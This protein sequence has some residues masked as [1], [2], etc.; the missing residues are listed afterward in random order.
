MK[1]TAFATSLPL[2]V[3]PSLCG[4]SHS[5]NRA[6]KTHVVPMNSAPRMAFSSIERVL[7]P[8]PVALP[9]EMEAVIACVYKQVFGNAYLMQSEREELAKTESQFARTENIREF[10][11]SL[12]KSNT[13]QSRFFHKVSQNRFIE[14]AFKHILGSAPVSKA[15]F[16]AAS[17]KYHQ[18]G[19]EACI[20]WFADSA[21]YENYFG[22]YIVPYG[23]FKGCYK[24]NELFNRSV[25]MRLTPCSSDKGRSNMLQYTVLS[26][27]SPNWL[28]ISK[29][30][31]LGTERGT[32]FSSISTQRNKNAPLRVG[33]KIPGGVVFYGA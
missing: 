13:Y 27:G 26:G 4:A 31:P 16:A 25:L 17:N 21:E 23:V 20:D 3:R 24:T 1:F 15:E 30:L 18:N 19:Y 12:A 5:V 8:A 9:G 22:D 14:L 29:A 28:S 7:T 6:P 33:T 2:S 32:G 10:V 11:R